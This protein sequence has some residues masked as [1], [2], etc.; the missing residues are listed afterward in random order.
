MAGFNFMSC[1]GFVSDEIDED[2]NEVF[3]ILHNL[4]SKESCQGHGSVVLDKCKLYADKRQIELR[5]YPW[6][7]YG[8]HARLK[9]WYLRN[10]FIDT[11]DWYVYYPPKE[12]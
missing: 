3:L 11:G 10:G 8:D 6:A 5:L 1:T 2:T 4:E 9:A 12:V 7:L